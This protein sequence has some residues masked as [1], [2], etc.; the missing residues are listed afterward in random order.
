MSNGYFSE[1][2]EE[3][4]NLM[5][6]SMKTVVIWDITLCSF[7]EDS[8]VSGLCHCVIWYK[9]TSI[10]DYGPLECLAMYFGGLVRM[11]WP[12]PTMKMKVPSS[13]KML[14]SIYHITHT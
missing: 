9:D 7:V 5:P 6:V 10:S 4:L 8:S 11:F 13:S 1:G 14:V 2:T 3:R 12:P